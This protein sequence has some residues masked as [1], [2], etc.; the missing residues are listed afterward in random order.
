M[1]STSISRP[2]AFIVVVSIALAGERALAQPRSTQRWLERFATDDGVASVF[3]HS[4]FDR[5][6]PRSEQPA[7]LALLWDAS[8]KEENRDL[9][10]SSVLAYLFGRSEG[11]LPWTTR[12]RAIVKSA[13]RSQNPD[14]RGL[15]VVTIIKRNA[16]TEMRAEII[17]ALQDD[18]EFVRNLAVGEIARWPDYRPLLTGYVRRNQGDKRHV[19]TVTRAKFLLEHGGIK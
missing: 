1:K 19:E 11:D 4:E 7:I 15:A 3:A 8:A 18:D 14:L 12:L 16:S 17:H 6:V 2:V 9:I 10:R 5:T 13:A